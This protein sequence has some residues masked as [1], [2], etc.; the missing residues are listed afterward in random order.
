[1]S[2]L[3]RPF[4]SLGQVGGEL[5]ESRGLPTLTFLHS[6]AVYGS[7]VPHL[8]AFSCFPVQATDRRHGDKPI[9]R[10]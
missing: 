5:D 1:M 7:G 9:E 4:S 6:T 8:F 10:C 3:G 2:L